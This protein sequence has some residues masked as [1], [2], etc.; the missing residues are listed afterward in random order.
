MQPYSMKTVYCI[1]IGLLVLGINYF[2]PI[3]DNV[4][5]D[6]IIRSTIAV[7]IYVPLLLAFNISPDI[8]GM[9]TKLLAQAK[10]RK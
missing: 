2:L 3:W 10:G 1:L 7:G 5:F 8:N 4:Y 9:V 6:I